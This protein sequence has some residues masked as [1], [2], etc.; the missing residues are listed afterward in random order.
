MAF[1]C[2][3]ANQE[4][5]DQTPYAVYQLKAGAGA[6]ELQ[7]QVA[8]PGWHTISVPSFFQAANRSVRL[9]AVHSGTSVNVDKEGNST[10]Y[11]DG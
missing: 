6:G 7:Y 2:G 10:T 5:H 9:T 3:L 1:E 11:Y 8:S 4:R